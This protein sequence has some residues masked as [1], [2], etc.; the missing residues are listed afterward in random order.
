ML[1][2][3]PAIA[4]PQETDLISGYVA[5]LYATWLEQLRDGDGDGW[6]TRRHRGLPSVFTWE[7]FDEQMRGFVDAAYTAVLAGKPGAR[8]VLDKN[9]SNSLH[10]ETIRRLVPRAKF[11]HLLRDGRDVAA[12]LVRAGRSEWGAWWAPSHARDAATIWRTHVAAAMT[13]ASEPDRYLEVRYEELRSPQ[14]AAHLARALEFCGVESDSA[15]ARALLERH[16]VGL[17]PPAGG[18][19]WGGEVR[20]RLPA[21]PREPDGFVGPARVGGWRT[22]LTAQELEAVAEAAGDLLGELG[23]TDAGRLVASAWSR[24]PRARSHGAQGATA[25][26]RARERHGARQA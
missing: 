14:G 12:S 3:H 23:Y 8:I 21:E 6:R 17:G 13:A 4:S 1:G 26:E 22:T 9:P 16:A 20:A 15:S 2:S 19:V 11:I 18:I 7:Q 10:V 24:W 25:P 5:P